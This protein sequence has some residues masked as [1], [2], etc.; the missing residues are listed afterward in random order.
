MKRRNLVAMCG[1]PQIIQLSGVTNAMNVALVNISFL[2]NTELSVMRFV[3][4]GYA[5]TLPQDCT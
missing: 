1:C 3:N 5:N 2:T 4:F